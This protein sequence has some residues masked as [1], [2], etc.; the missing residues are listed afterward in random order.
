[1]EQVKGTTYYLLL[2]IIVQ[3][4]KLQYQTNRQVD[5]S[6]KPNFGPNLGLNGPNF[7]PIF[8]AQHKKLP[9]VVK[10]H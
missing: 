6:Q 1:M 3:N 7:E 9:L 4:Q 5:S 2:K 8:F 10:Y